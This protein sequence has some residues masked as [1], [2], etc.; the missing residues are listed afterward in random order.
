MCS[1]GKHSN[2]QSSPATLPF[3]AIPGPNLLENIVRYTRKGFRDYHLFLEKNFKQYGPIFKFVM[4]GVKV[5]HVC[6]P[7]DIERVY[8]NEGYPASRGGVMAASSYYH[9]KGL[10]KGLNGG[11]ESW[12]IQRSAVAPKFLR[13]AELQPFFEELCKAA[14]DVV[15]SFKDGRNLDISD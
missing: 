10:P 6:D 12:Y 9:E 14:G 11:D 4:P 8:R 15:E 3:D 2:K 1:V 7:D 13:P 5:V